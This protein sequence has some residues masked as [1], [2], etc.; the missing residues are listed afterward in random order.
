MSFQY[1]A[2]NQCFSMEL[3]DI[4]FSCESEYQRFESIAENL[5]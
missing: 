4:L 2:E 3:N 1:D 5:A